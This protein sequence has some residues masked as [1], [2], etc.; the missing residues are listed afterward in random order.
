MAVFD[1]CGLVKIPGGCGCSLPLGIQSIAAHGVLFSKLVGFISF[2]HTR[3][4]F[5][6][7][8]FTLS[9]DP[10]TI[11]SLSNSAIWLASLSAA[12]T[13]SGLSPVMRSF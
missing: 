9:S 10:S 13:S 1:Q 2:D 12:G 4:I 5:H 3:P 7:P 6:D 11:R 8:S